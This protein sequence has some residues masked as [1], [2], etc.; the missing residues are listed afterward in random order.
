MHS[1]ALGSLSFSPH[2]LR[3]LTI[4]LAPTALRTLTHSH[5]I[6]PPLVHVGKKKPK[7]KNL[8]DCNG[9]LSFHLIC[10]EEGRE[11]AQ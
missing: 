7:K 3:P 8:K 4:S 1:V 6:K 9:R 10:L 2:R 11:A 5:L